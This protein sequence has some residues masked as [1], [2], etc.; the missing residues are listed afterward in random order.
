MS[1]L[2]YFFKAFRIELSGGRR[3]IGVPGDTNENTRAG[4]ALF[5]G[6]P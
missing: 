5:P 6:A 4:V 1:T 3:H 2:M